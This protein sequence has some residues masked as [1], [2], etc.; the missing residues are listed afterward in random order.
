MSHFDLASWI[1]TQTREVDRALDRFLPK[2][3]AKPATIHKAMR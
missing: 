2:A 1:A 3:A